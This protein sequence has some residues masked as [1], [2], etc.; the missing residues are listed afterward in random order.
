MFN[1]ISDTKWFEKKIK[2]ALE[3]NDTK[4][5]F[6]TTHFPPYNTVYGSLE[7]GNK[8]LAECFKKYPQIIN[9][10]GHSHYSLIDERSIYHKDCTA[11]Q[12]QSLSYIELEYGKI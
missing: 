3:D 11:I 8:I 1:L 2:I 7:W 12:T 6:V 5:I 4:P 10:S 9:F